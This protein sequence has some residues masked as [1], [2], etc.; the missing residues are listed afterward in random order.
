MGG[1]R[2]AI[3][4]GMMD[5][6]PLS[7]LEAMV[8]G[9]FPI[10]SNTADTEGWIED[11]KNGLL[12]APED[13]NAIAVAI[14]EATLNDQMVDQAAE[15]NAQITKERIDIGIVK[16]KVIEIYKEIAERKR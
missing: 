10:Q 6:T 11:G 15:I 1:A 8:M 16:P 13:A 3:S 14:R 2:I 7:M 12:V 4:V 9:A 5:G